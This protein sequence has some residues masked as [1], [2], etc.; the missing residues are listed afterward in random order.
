MSSQA[1]LCKSK[2]RCAT[3]WH[4]NL[5]ILLKAREGDGSKKGLSTNCSALNL[6]VDMITMLGYSG[7]DNGAS[8]NDEQNL[9]LAVD[10]LVKAVHLWGAKKTLDF[11]RG[12]RTAFDGT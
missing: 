12:G 5:C 10:W 4:T 6:N 1:L 9:H 7:N 3:A 2:R 8:L 11:H